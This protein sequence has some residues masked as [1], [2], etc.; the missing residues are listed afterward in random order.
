VCIIVTDNFFHAANVQSDQNEAFQICV[1]DGKT[2]TY[3]LTVC[4][5]FFLLPFMVNKDVH[6]RL[7]GSH[8]IVTV[9]RPDLCCN[10]WYN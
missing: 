4:A 2:P 7:L 5:A 10:N 3:S 1:V 6:S 8:S 9:T